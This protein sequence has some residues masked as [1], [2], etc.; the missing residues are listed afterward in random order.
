M[1]YTHVVFD[2]DGT[3]I[4]SFRVIAVGLCEAMKIETG[5][6]FT[7]QEV[8]FTFGMPADAGLR[9]L[10]AEDPR[11]ALEN[12]EKYV[13]EHARE[14]RPYDGVEDTLVRLSQSGVHLGVITSKTREEYDVQFAGVFPFAS[15]F[16]EAVCAGDTAHGKP[17]PEPLYRYMDLTG[18]RA[19]EILYVGDTMYDMACAASAGVDGALAVWG[20]N[21]IKHIRAA[22][23]AFSPADVAR[24]ALSVRDPYARVP[25]LPFAMEL[26]F[27]AQT[28]IAYSKDKYDI[29]RFE[30]LREMAGEIIGAYTEMPSDAVKDLF[31]NEKGYQTPKLDCRAAVFENDG[32]LLVQE[33]DGLWALPGGWV[34]VNLSV[35]E[36]MVKEAREETGL[37]VAPLRL[38]AL[39]D[40]NKHISPPY[41]YGIATAFI[42]C[43]VVS[44]AFTPNIE[45]IAS[46]YFSLDALPPLCT[47]KTTRAQIEM[48]FSAHA[49]A[50]WKT[51]FD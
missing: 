34:D 51:I 14:I 11:R 48:C 32:I 4:D 39:L 10:N 12:W 13:A 7:F 27:I 41:P 40:R 2:I 30:R 29:E 17:S 25:W 45:T 46:G 37:T 5:R 38:I 24:I 1:R 6:P 36:N 44:G 3:L 20:A 26:Q 16:K 21:A 15:M 35:G 49:D 23:Y 22:H 8:A 50:Q 43:G 31:L 42:E 47:V 28:G 33:N 19:E 9:A 18:A